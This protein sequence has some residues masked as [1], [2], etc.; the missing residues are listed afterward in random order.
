M[1][2]QE[3]FDTLEDLATN[4]LEVMLTS[5]YITSEKLKT[6]L[7]STKEG[8]AISGEL[9][10]MHEQAIDSFTNCD[11]SNVEAMQ[12]AKMDL[13]LTKKVYEF[14]NGI[15]QDGEIARKQLSGELE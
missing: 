7:T 6:W 2:Q 12:K 13:E 14:F 3:S 15:F 8:K 9:V 4:D 10:S 1:E 5:K 11:A